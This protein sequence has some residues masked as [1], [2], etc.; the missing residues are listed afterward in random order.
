M[1]Q[2]THNDHLLQM[3]EN[4]SDRPVLASALRLERLT[5]SNKKLY[6]RTLIVSY[7][8]FKLQSFTLV[9]KC[10]QSNL[11]ILQVSGFQRLE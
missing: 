9:Q 10:L 1:T 6:T 11:Q 4:V 8:C 7:L 2:L 3:S 5:V